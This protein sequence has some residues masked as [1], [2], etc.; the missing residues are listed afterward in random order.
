MPSCTTDLGL[1]EQ[2]LPQGDVTLGGVHCHA[3]RER[4]GAVLAELGGQGKHHLLGLHE[5]LGRE[6]II[7]H[8]IHPDLKVLEETLQQ[9]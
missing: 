9:R 5:A 7:P 2:G 6:Q 3:V 4:M 8:A 1:G